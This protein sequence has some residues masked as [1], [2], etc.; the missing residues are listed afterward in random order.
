MNRFGVR[1]ICD[2]TF[3]PLA[4]VDI[5]NH[6]FD[7][8]QPVLYLDTAK[9][10]S[11]EQAATT[12]YAQGGRGN[13]RLVAWQGDKTLTMTIE[14]ALLST[15]SFQVLSGAGV[16]KGAKADAANNIV[17]QPIYT[18]NTYDL[19]VEKSGAN[20]I[21]KLTSEDRQNAQLIISKEAPIYAVTLDS[22]G[23]AQ[24]YLSAIT[25]KEVFLTKADGSL[26]AQAVVLEA[27]GRVKDS[28]TK[29]LAF[30]IGKDTP[31]D[32][33]LDNVKAGDTVRIDCYT[34]HYEDAIEMT[35]EA[36]TFGGFYYVEASTLFRD[37]ATGVDLPA[38]F[39]IPRAQVQS[40]FTFSMAATGDPSTFTFTLDCFP[41]Y[42]KFN[43]T[44]K[45][46]AALQ[47][48]DK[49]GAG[50][51]YENKSILGHKGRT[52]DADIDTWYTKSI[53]TG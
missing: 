53:F 20:F 17:E 26:E 41:A 47:V 40:N 50:H 33:R 25:E 19:V 7:A 14:D 44:T 21:A 35:I 9:T 15:T 3:K 4:S 32:D 5:G 27:D 51:S 38:E 52:K 10:S 6:H 46:L 16:I 45:V 8:Y 42:T 43:R 18:H 30:V 29:T 12:V 34:V 39:V 24:N 28:S 49:A 1:E 36:D 2:V 11:L 13:P 22:V 48:I 37:E 23:A 31:G